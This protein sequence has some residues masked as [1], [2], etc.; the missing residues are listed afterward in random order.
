MIRKTLHFLGPKSPIGPA[1]SGALSGAVGLVIG[2]PILVLVGKFL[3]WWYEFW[4]T[5]F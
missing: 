3:I 1:A 2:A 4:A 5:L